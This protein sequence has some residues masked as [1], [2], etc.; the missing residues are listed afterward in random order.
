MIDTSRTLRTISDE[1]EHVACLA[2]TPTGV[3][4]RFLAL[5]RAFK[6]RHHPGISLKRKRRCEE[7]PSFIEPPSVLISNCL[8]GGIHPN[9][10]ELDRGNGTPACFLI[11]TLPNE[12]RIVVTQAMAQGL[13]GREFAVDNV[14][15]EVHIHTRL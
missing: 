12:P 8:N 5:E 3:T 14:V 7:Q 13:R 9:A 10:N 4:M 2:T 1:F 11:A 15:I 6:R